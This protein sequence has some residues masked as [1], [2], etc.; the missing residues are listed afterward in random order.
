MK[1]LFLFL[2]ENLKWIVLIL[3]P[4]SVLSESFA[5]PVFYD[6]ANDERIDLID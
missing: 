5:L 6:R 2:L 3:S 4:I 1:T